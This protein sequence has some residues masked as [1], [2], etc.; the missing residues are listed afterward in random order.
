MNFEKTDPQSPANQ[1]FL[2]LYSPEKHENS[3]LQWQHPEILP[4]SENPNI[5]NNKQEFHEEN[6]GPQPIKTSVLKLDFLHELL[7][8]DIELK[9]RELKNNSNKNLVYSLGLKG[10]FEKFKGVSQEKNLFYTMKCE[11]KIENTPKIEEKVGKLT[12]E[13]RKLKVEKYQEKKRQRKWLEKSCLLKKISAGKRERCNGKFKKKK[14]N[15]EEESI[16]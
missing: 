8:D 6:P 7:K 9:R 16:S 15:D 4:W 5:F 11:K 3:D 10:L 12:K 1:N 13:Q 2:L 14:E